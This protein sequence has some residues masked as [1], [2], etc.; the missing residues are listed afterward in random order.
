ML[1]EQVVAIALIVVGMLGLLTVLGAGSRAVVNGRQ[2][3]AATSLGRQA[4]E[5][6]QGGAYTSVA[7]DLSSPGLSSDPRVTGTAPVLA[8]EGELLVGGAGAP[9]QASEEAAGI[10]YTISTFVTAV[11][12]VQGLPYRRLTVF[13]D[14]TPSLSGSFH[15]Q[16]FSTLVYPLDYRSYP[17]GSGLAEITGGRVTVTG[18]LDS[19]T[20]EDARMALPAARAKT[21][22]STLRSAH[23]T[24]SSATGILDLTAGGLVATGCTVT[25]T[26]TYVGQCPVSTVDKAADNDSGTSSP[27]SSTAK[28]AVLYGGASAQTPGGLTLSLPTDSGDAHASVEDCGGCGYGDDDGTVWADA[29]RTT[30]GGAQAS[31]SLGGGLTG[32]LWTAGAGWSATATVDH[33]TSGGD[34]VT[35]TGRLTAPAAKVFALD[36]AGAFD[37][38]VLVGGTT[39][40]TAT[41]TASAGDGSA[42]PLATSTS[43]RVQLW[44]GATY[45][46]VDITPGVFADESASAIL[47]VSGHTVSIHSRVQSAPA[48]STSTGATPHHLVTG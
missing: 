15:S 41:A 42:G 36:G 29:T 46:P 17:A 16:R 2:R 48:I 30:S 31:F 11:V 6:L 37:A 8:F 32:R 13:V 38:A 21:N 20:F 44:D 28:G 7:M 24:A 4:L 45:R 3:T 1:V 25:G 14:W 10:T 34:R 18:H 33:D 9:Y 26:P 43:V 47:T 35:A 5:R 27:S 12:P 39:G 19:D 40:F 22:A 23:G